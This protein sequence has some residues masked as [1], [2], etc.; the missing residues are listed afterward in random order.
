MLS[1]ASANRAGQLPDKE[2]QMYYVERDE[3]SAKLT[4][5]E[6]DVFGRVKN[7]P[8]MMFGDAVGE[9]ERQMEQM[10]QRLSEARKNGG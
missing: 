10:F 1:D 8:S 5:L 4:T 2:G 3:P 6:V 7:W 9:T